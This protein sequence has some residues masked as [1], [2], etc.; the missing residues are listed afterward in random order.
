[1]VAP[2]TSLPAASKWRSELRFF[3]VLMLGTFALNSLIVKPFYIPSESMLPGLMT[4]DNIVVSKFPYGW[5]FISPSFH[6]LPPL[7]GRLFGRVPRRGD[8]V[9][10]T[11]PDRERRSEDWI[12]RV[13]GLPGDQVQMVNGRLWLNGRRVHTT[14]L[15]RRAFPVDPNFACRG[16]GQLSRG[17]RSCSLHIIRETLPD[18]TSYD[19]IENGI[20][21]ADDT[22]PYVV[23]AG[24][25]FVMGDNRD[26]SADS[27]VPIA[28]TGLGGAI[29]VENIAGRAEFI[30][31]SVDGSAGWNPLRWPW[32]LRTERAGVSLHPKRAMP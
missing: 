9:V 6:L 29:P 30:S 31:F 28:Q 3:A 16:G 7:P 4:G 26:N 10:F 15:G 14:D 22:P 5:S 23:P 20:G 18:G 21:A 32:S 12:K 11:P 13:I 2:D 19:T 27:R 17:G 25:V 8:V 1:M 24:H